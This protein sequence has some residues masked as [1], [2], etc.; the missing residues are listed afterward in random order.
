MK[1][2]SSKRLAYIGCLGLVSIISTEFGVIGILPQIA[3][4]YRISI[5]QAGYLLSLFALIIAL[6]GPFMMLYT[7]TFN[8]KRVMLFAILIFLL[9]NTLSFFKPSFAW[10]IIFRLS[11]AFLHPVFIALSIASASKNT[12]SKTQIR[13]T[14]IIVGGIPLAQ[15]T[16]IPLTTYIASITDWNMVYLLQAIINAIVLVLIWFLIPKEPVEKNISPTDQ[17]AILKKKSFLW[18][19]AFNFFLIAAWFCT[20]SYFANYLQSLYGFNDKEIGF[21]LMFFGITG[22]ISNAF[23]SRLLSNK[24]MTTTLV[25]V[26]GTVIFPFL[27]HFGPL[28]KEYGILIVGLWGLLYG[29]CFITAITF[30]QSSAPEAKSFSNTLQTSFG[31]LGISVGTFV[32]GV[33]IAKTGVFI[34]PWVGATFGMLCLGCL[35]VRL[36]IDKQNTACTQ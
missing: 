19:I 26:L 35:L 10:L 18:S 14:G 20:Y 30:M 25:I 6:T 4:Y 8:A 12:D 2:Q 3:T 32:S 9:S 31:N 5:D 22:F 28:Y 21:L 34:S 17:I 23:G 11:P 33:A 29:P 15:V 36:K 13:N 1:I 24:P 16:I 7:S 27:T